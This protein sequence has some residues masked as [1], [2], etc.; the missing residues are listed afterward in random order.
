MFRLK[1]L[2]YALGIS[3][4]LIFC[5]GF[6]GATEKATIIFTAGMTEISSDNKGRYPELAHLLKQHRQS[7]TPTFFLF[8]GDSLSPS[9]LSS[10]DRGTHIID[11]LN[12]LEPDAMGVDKREF[13]FL[14]DELSLRAYE[15]AFPIVASNLKDSL[16]KGNLDGLIESTVVQQG[17]YKLGIISVINKNVIEEYAL[18]RITVLDE[19][20]AIEKESKKLRSSGVDLIVL[21]YSTHNPEIEQL[22]ND[23]IIDI[24]FCKDAYFN[25]HEGPNNIKHKNNIFLSKQR[26]VVLAE[27]KWEKDQATSLNIDWQTKDLSL[28]PKDPDVYNQVI[29]YTDRLSALLQQK[30]GLLETPM[31]TGHTIVRTEENPFA[32]FVTDAMKSYTNSDIALLNSG[33]IRGESYYPANTFLTRKDIGKEIP[34]R[35]KIILLEVTGKQLVEALENGFSIIEQIKGRFPQVS[36]MQIKYDSSAPSGKRVISVLINGKPL[37]PSSIY[38]LAT[39]DY[40]ASGGD[41][42]STFKTSNSLRYDNQMFR[43]IVDIVMDKIKEQ[44]NIR[45]NLDSRLIDAAKKKS[46]QR[47]G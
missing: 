32:N 7:G 24:S 1:S 2:I 12:S 36:G 18:T 3:F 45:L 16:T 44:K 15:A 39:S 34:F 25:S 14:E 29:S 43:L 20:Q 4:K 11:L 37:K 35:N 8:G 33:S 17:N 46:L 41:G 28:Y 6:V 27:L 30:I 47:N 19:K 9:P 23:N 13:G 42:Y 10:L 22:L 26:H 5:T 40:I 21:L 38:K 31:D